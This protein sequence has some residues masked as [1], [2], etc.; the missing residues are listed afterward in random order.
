MLVTEKKRVIPGARNDHVININVMFVP[1]LASCC[2][3]MIVTEINAWTLEVTWPQDRYHRLSR[4]S[5]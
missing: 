4:F 5:D 3:G 2:K 1:A